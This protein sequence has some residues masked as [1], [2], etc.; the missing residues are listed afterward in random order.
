[1][2]N[3]LRPNWSDIDS[4][5]LVAVLS[6]V[7]GGSQLSSEDTV[8]YPNADE[9]RIT[10]R[11]EEGRIASIT[12]GPEF[13]TSEWA[14]V[15]GRIEKELLE[16]TPAIARNI[17]FCSYRVHGWWRSDK[18]PL[19]ILPPPPEAP[20]A[21]VELAAH[22]FVI[23]L[24]IMKSANWVVTN[25]RRTREYRRLTALLSVLLEGQVT[26]ISPTVRHF[27][28]FLADATAAAWVQEG[29]FSPN[30]QVE[31]DALSQPKG[32]PMVVVA[33]QD[34]YSAFGHESWRGLQVPETLEHSLEAYQG[35][36]PAQRKRFDRA[37]YWWD[38][39]D[40]FWSLSQSASYGALVTAVEALVEE[41]TGQGSCPT[42]RRSLAPGPTK[43]FQDFLETYTSGGGVMAR[44]RAKMYAVRSAI[45]HGGKLMGNDLEVEWG[46]NPATVSERDLHGDLW[47]LVRNALINW[48]LRVGKGSD[49]LEISPP[50]RGRMSSKTVSFRGDAQSS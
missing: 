45:S 32:E 50:K 37:C 23:E 18:L 46:L 31:A 5:D 13:D 41:P 21:P 27:W 30:F 44:A 47:R 14:A 39:K 24:P 4:G 34:Y 48:L 2:K 33:A 19:Q 15:G 3:L 43:L 26:S 28:A 36:S 38:M 49:M 17:A 25:N 7:F 40:R 9:A 6:Q 16:S 29:Y 42:C 22:P 10:L 20:V 1:M 35:L 11:Y 12:P 8:S